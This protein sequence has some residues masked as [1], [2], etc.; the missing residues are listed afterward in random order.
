MSRKR[1]NRESRRGE[2]M[3]ERR[4]GEGDKNE[5]KGV[6]A[7]DARKEEVEEKRGRR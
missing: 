2:W 5:H 6:E 3:R 4:R 1:R 7:E